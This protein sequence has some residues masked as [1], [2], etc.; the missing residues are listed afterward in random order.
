MNEFGSSDRFGVEGYA[1]L[2][3]VRDSAGDIVSPGAFAR[4][5]AKRSGRPL[6]MLFQHEARE[7]I[8]FW[9]AVREDSR[10][11][12]V[13][14]RLLPGVARARELTALIA[15]KAVDGLSIGYR[16][17]RA[18]RDRRSAARVILEADLWEISL[19]LF[20]VLAGA[21]V[22]RAGHEAPSPSTKG[23]LGALRRMTHSLRTTP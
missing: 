8:G 12:F 17:V 13:R 23:A 3:D 21:R 4:S 10:G 20:P 1:S 6:P 14:G 7:P 16:T 18:S 22:R 15:A 5:L 2:F 19:V 9:S 11:L